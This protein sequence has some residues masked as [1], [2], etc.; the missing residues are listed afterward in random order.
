MEI[1]WKGTV[2]GNCANFHTRK[3]GEITVFYAVITKE[4]VV[5]TEWVRFG[6]D[7]GNTFIKAKGGVKFGSWTYDRDC[8][9]WKITH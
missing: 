3:L 7:I 9:A 5:S 1:L 8:M 4:N 6:D 2:Y